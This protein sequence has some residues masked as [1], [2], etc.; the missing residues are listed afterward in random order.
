MNKEQELAHLH[1]PSTDPK[2]RQIDYWGHRTEIAEA[3]IERL[4]E[5]LISAKE[6]LALYRKAQGGEYLG[7]VE[8]R[9][10]MRRI[11]EALGDV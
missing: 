4:R 1:A 7:G 6:K 9:E 3:K 10:L 8:Y 2:Q 11:D 5:V